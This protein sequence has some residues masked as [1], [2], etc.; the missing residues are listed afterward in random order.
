MTAFVRG[1]ESTL[2]CVELSCYFSLPDPPNSSLSVCFRSPILVDQGSSD[3]FQEKPPTSLIMT[4]P[5]RYVVGPLIDTEIE[6]DR[7]PSGWLVGWLVLV[8]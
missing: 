3:N 6:T 7:S 1:V 2:G 5:V 4:Q 8:G